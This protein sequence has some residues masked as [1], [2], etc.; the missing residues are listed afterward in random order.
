MLAVIRPLLMG[1]L[2]QYDSLAALMKPE[3]H[4]AV[5]AGDYER[6]L[7]DCI[8]L[9]QSW[10]LGGHLDS[11][12][13]CL[14]MLSEA[15]PQDWSGSYRQSAV[16]FVRGD[17]VLKTDSDYASALKYYQLGYENSEKYGDIHGMGVAL[18]ASVYIFYILADEYGMRYARQLERLSMTEGSDGYTE[19][20]ACIAL[21]QMYCVQGN[22][23]ES[24]RYLRKVDS[25]AEL[26]DAY[27]YPAHVSLISGDIYRM[28]GEY[29]EAD[30]C[31]G[32]AMRKAEEGEV[33][34]IPLICL[35]QGSMFYECG[36]FEEAAACFGKGVDATYRYANVEVRHKLLQRLSDLYYDMG[37]AETSLMYYMRQRQEIRTE[38]RNIPEADFGS[39]LLELQET[40]YENEIQA[41][42]LALSR[43]RQH[44][45]V[46]VSVAALVVLLL[47][48]VWVLYRRKQ[49]MYRAL[50]KQY[51]NMLARPFLPGKSSAEIRTDRSDAERE[52]FRRI[53]DYM[54][55]EKAWRR[56]ELSLDML[57]EHFNTNR[58]YVSNAINRA[59]NMT[60][61]AYVNMYRIREAVEIIS[62]DNNVLLKQ[63][64]DTVGFT[65]PTLF[66]KAFSSETGVTPTQ[67]KKALSSVK[68]Q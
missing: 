50:V 51:E 61:A 8:Y 22:L 42:E 38:S 16:D 14:D 5:A 7:F 17:L 47:L 18:S 10:L 9:A 57:A 21:A 30:S 6:A 53:D 65:S 31:Y 63:L 48:S 68:E 66:T 33:L 25:M 24:Y 62:Q 2:P 27:M 39:L 46:S 15:E 32:D 11:V 3:F 4:E 43:A 26:Y 41:G 45:V 44:I 52:L 28:S 23:A 55:S 35:S 40:E 37:D 34:L 54:V 56:K 1:P 13:L 12:R 67:Y 58:T 20:N 59:G 60:F 64:A 19:Q 49:Q 36:N 29:R